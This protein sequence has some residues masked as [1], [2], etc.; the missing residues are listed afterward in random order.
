MLQIKERSSERRGNEAS[1][2]S[3]EEQKRLE[4]SENVREE[5]YEEESKQAPTVLLDG[6][7]L[8]RIEERRQQSLRLTS[9]DF[10]TRLQGSTIEFDAYQEDFR[11]NKDNDKKTHNPGMEETKNNVTEVR[12]QMTEKKEMADWRVEG[13]NESKQ[14]FDEIDSAV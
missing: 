5:E 10:Q 9:I 7:T 6:N 13:L 12:E 14:R 4:I 8:S 2:E 11:L 1:I 3:S